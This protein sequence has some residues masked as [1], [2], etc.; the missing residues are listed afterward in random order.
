MAALSSVLFI[1]LKF[2]FHKESM[3]MSLSLVKTNQR[4]C[5]IRVQT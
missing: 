2:E 3:H 4:K 5:H 1:Y